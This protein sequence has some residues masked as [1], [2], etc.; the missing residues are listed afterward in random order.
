MKLTCSSAFFLSVLHSGDSTG[1]KT[2]GTLLLSIST[3]S[4][5]GRHGSLQRMSCVAEHLD[6][7]WQEDKGGLGWNV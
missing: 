4:S 1:G 3:A 6:R 7:P 2:A 5:A